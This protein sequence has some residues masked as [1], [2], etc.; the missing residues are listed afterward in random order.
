MTKQ[1]LRTIYKQ[2]RLALTS[3]EQ[4]KLDDLLL[5][6][7]QTVSLPFLTT[8]LSYWPM[9]KNKEPN[10][11]LFTDYIEF[12]N[13][14]IQIAYPQTDFGAGTMQAAIADDQTE[15]ISSAKGIMEP[16]T[17]NILDA[18]AIEAVFVPLLIADKRGY[19][20]GYGKGFYDR[21]LATCRKDCLKIGFSYFEPVEE[22]TDSDEF[23]IPLSHCIT[24]QQVYVF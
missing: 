13:P 11:H 5:I 15:F 8:L 12:K 10:T 9:E 7:F 19:R 14:G 2:K 6:Q 24:P 22:I 16:I 17:S 21:Y 3:K 20:L 1:E 23:D 4:S 18:L